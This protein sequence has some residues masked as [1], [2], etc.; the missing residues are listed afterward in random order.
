MGDPL[1]WK[2]SCGAVYQ[3]ERNL[4]AH[5][6]AMAERNATLPEIPAKDDLNKREKHERADKIGVEPVPRRPR[7]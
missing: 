2:C 5:V 6:K 4:D 7:Q 3:A 1:E